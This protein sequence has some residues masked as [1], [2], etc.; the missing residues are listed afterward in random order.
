M[1]RLPAD[2]HRFW[3]DPALP[4]LEARAVVEGRSVCY[5]PHSHRTFS[6]GLITG[7]RNEFRIGDRRHE[8]ATGAVVMMNP[9]EVHVCTPREGFAWSYRMLYVDAR[10][11]ARTEGL[12]AFRP[13][14]TVPITDPA[15]FSD[16]LA[17][18]DALFDGDRPA[19][20][21]DRLATAFFATLRGRL[22]PAEHSPAGAHPALARV[23]SLLT[24][25]CAEPVTLDRIASASGLSRSHLVRAF[26]TRYGLTPHAYLVNRRI[27]LGQAALRDGRPIAE[28]ALDAG[29]ADQAHFQRAFKRHTAVTPGQYVQTSKAR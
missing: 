11:L 16:L 21:K 22:K 12:P 26:K 4:H 9:D 15:L 7:G 1:P 3:R 17:L 28:A 5:E 6:I 20:D 23:A 18:F 13:F 2:P 24:Q 25:Q 27:Q 10:W 29:F 19:A 8:I 14:A